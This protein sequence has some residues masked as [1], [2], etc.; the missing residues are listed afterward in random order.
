MVHLDLGHIFFPI[1]L[2]FLAFISSLFFQF[3][4][5][6][7]YVSLLFVFKTESNNKILVLKN[8]TKKKIESTNSN[9]NI[10]FKLQRRVLI[11]LELDGYLSQANPIR[12]NQIRDYGAIFKSW[13]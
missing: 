1:L 11:L 9:L 3:P 2:L 7:S 13:N 6:S 5:L 10:F 8:Y 4:H 12:S